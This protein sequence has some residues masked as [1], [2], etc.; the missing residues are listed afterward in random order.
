METRQDTFFNSLT[1]GI[2]LVGQDDV[3][4]YANAAALSHLCLAVGERIRSPKLQEALAATRRAAPSKASRLDL[5]PCS[6]FAREN[7]TVQVMMSPFGH[8]TLLVLGRESA[9]G[10]EAARAIG[11]LINQHCRTPMQGFF[12]SAEIAV[13]ALQARNPADSEIRR[14]VERAIT[15]GKAAVDKLGQ[16]LAIAHA[17]EGVPMKM[18]ERLTLPLLL[19]E[20]TLAARGLAE[21]RR[22]RIFLEGLEAELPAIYGSREWLSR[23]LYELIASALMCGS[24]GADVLVSVSA[25]EGKV[26]IAARVAGSIKTLPSRDETYT[27]FYSEAHTE[28]LF[29]R[30]LGIGLSFTR[31][32]IER[33]G[34]QFFVSDDD[35]G[36][37][38]FAAV[39]PS[40]LAVEERGF[41]SLRQ[42]ER[43]A[44]DLA[45]LINERGAR[46][47]AA[48]WSET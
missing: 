12:A 19:D 38:E 8:E 9:N 26:M 7:L 48:L 18:D 1:E 41:D 17:A 13:E 6:G 2:V 39:L 45:R 28:G 16:L 47:P 3:I 46:Q 43:Y 44:E 22:M 25:I 36:I 35:N 21:P 37:A 14:V 20:A 15:Q 5:A 42:A 4:R 10:G 29:T 32:V 31:W 24:N 11:Q 33:H 23:S 40:G 27:P 30:S 34:G